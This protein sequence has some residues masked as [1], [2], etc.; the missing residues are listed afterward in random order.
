[1]DIKVLI[2]DLWVVEKIGITL[3]TTKEQVQHDID[4]P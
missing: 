3:T 4:Q 2:G 1:M